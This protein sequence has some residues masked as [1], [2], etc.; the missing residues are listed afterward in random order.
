[1]TL[2]R[3]S[4][5]FI[6]LSVS[7]LRILKTYDFISAKSYQNFFS[8]ASNCESRVNTN[9]R[10]EFDLN[11]DRIDFRLL[12]DASLSDLLRDFPA[13]VAVTAGQAF[14]SIGFMPDNLSNRYL[15]VKF[16]EGASP[17]NSRLFGWIKVSSGAG[18][19]TATVHSWG[20][21]NDGGKIFTVADNFSSTVLNLSSGKNRIVWNAESEDGIARYDV[22]RKEAG[23]WITISAEIPAG[24]NEGLAQYSYVDNNLN[25]DAEYRVAA[26]K[27]NGEVTIIDPL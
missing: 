15:A 9:N 18:G 24:N 20:Y 19:K 2:Q 21:Q 8:S 6:L 11:S 27:V 16:D 17:T 14:G 25:K 7:S 13:G 22:E 12:N 23:K 5:N 3:V 10:L 4:M 26:I 1:S